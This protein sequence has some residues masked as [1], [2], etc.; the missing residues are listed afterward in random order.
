MIRLVSND[1]NLSL[2]EAIWY[3]GSFGWEESFRKVLR[4]SRVRLKFDLPSSLIKYGSLTVKS[5]CGKYSAVTR[6]V[7]A[8]LFSLSNGTRKKMAAEKM[9]EW[10][11]GWKKKRPII[12]S[13]VRNNLIAYNNLKSIFSPAS[14]IVVKKFYILFG[15]LFNLIIEKI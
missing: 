3:F 8:L 15:I 4:F 10:K 11:N 5:D 9:V 12:F 2:G 14:N 1:T 6:K 13:V 7:S